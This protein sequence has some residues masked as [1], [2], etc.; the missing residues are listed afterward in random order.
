MRGERGVSSWA[1]EELVFSVQVWFQHAL[2]FL[3]QIVPFYFLLIFRFIWMF[4]CRHQILCVFVESKT[5]FMHFLSDSSL[6]L[7]AL[8]MNNLNIPLFYEWFEYITASD[9]QKSHSC[10]LLISPVLAHGCHL[11]WGSLRSWFAWSPLDISSV[12]A[13]LL[14]SF[15]HSPVSGKSR[16]W[17]SD[18]DWPNN[19]KRVLFQRL[20]MALLPSTTL[21]TKATSSVTTTC[22]A[23]LCKAVYC[24]PWISY[25]GHGC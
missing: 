8:F 10:F 6:A 4:E 19:Y 5:I 22:W 18:L 7:L 11:K 1:E 14:F 13:L 3:F 24:R 23:P 2:H 9:F 21:C 25:S 16:V 15:V 12:L 20:Q 17:G